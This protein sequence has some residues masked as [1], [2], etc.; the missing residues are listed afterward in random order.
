MTELC[1]MTA[2]KEMIA[3]PVTT[4]DPVLTVGQQSLLLRRR[5]RARSRAEMR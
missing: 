4:V 5:T 3:V 2:V 1:M